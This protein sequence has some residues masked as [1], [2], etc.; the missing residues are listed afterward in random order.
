MSEEEQPEREGHAK[1]E[2]DARH[3]RGD[4]GVHRTDDDHKA[5]GNA[6]AWCEGKRG[7]QASSGIRQSRQE[8]RLLDMHPPRCAVS[9]C[10][11]KKSG[12]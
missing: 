4:G 1:G 11:R 9:A 7:R 5:H 6:R 8:K 12:R 10:N 2:R 3:G